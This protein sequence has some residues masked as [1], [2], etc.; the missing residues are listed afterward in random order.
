MSRQRTGYGIGGLRLRTLPPLRGDGGLC[1]STKG[2]PWLGS[3]PPNKVNK[4]VQLCPVQ[5]EDI[6]KGATSK[7]QRAQSRVKRFCRPEV[8]TSTARDPKMDLP[9]TLRR[10]FPRMHCPGPVVKAPAYTATWW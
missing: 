5:S 10:T 8:T 4:P 1:R 3:D 2:T 7:E 6:G 9:V